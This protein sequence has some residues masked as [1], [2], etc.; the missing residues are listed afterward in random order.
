MTVHNSVKYITQS[1]QLGE[2]ERDGK[3]NVIKKK[4]LPKKQNSQNFTRH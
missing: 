1:E 4:S 3:P 2:R